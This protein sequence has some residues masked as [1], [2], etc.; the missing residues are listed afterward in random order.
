M[1]LAAVALAAFGCGAPPE[2]GETEEGLT[3]VIHGPLPR[4]VPLPIAQ[5]VYLT[6]DSVTP[7]VPIEGQ[8]VQVVYDLWNN[9][10]VVR[11]GWVGAKVTPTNSAPYTSAMENDWPVAQLPAWAFA[12][13]VATFTA[14]KADH[15]H[16]FQLYYYETRPIIAEFR[17]PGPAV[18]TSDLQAL[19][20]GARYYVGVTIV[21]ADKQREPNDRKDHDVAVCAGLVGNG[22]PVPCRSVG[23]NPDNGQG[24]KDIGTLDGLSPVLGVGLEAGPFVTVP[25]VGPDVHFSFT[26]AD[27]G[28]LG[29]D[30]L[31]AVLDGISTAT[32]A[33]LTYVYPAFTAAWAALNTGT[34]GLNQLMFGECKGLVADDQLTF[35]TDQLNGYTQ[36]TPNYTFVKQ[37]G[38]DPLA[39]NSP[40]ISGWQCGNH[41]IYDV[42]YIIHRVPWQPND[43]L[44]VVP[45][46]KR[47]SPA[48]TVA[49]TT[50]AANN[51]EVTWT[52][53]S[54]T[55]TGL[56]YITPGG[57]FG[58][59]QAIGPNDLVIIQAKDID[60]TIGH[61]YVAG[62]LP[63]VM[64][65]PH[66]PLVHPI[67]P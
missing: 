1:F 16:H 59:N 43:R 24:A 67:T 26:A 38:T 2:A 37:Y 32:A 35:T 20:V 57:V 63:P 8:P 50:N 6:I 30:N 45:F 44:N 48:A 14:P 61:A 65:V 53:D 9:T 25:R 7:A 36:T 19:D 33:V 66:P 58:L 51:S 42:H 46:V 39:P 47:L 34:A 21:A 17:Q 40:Y 12:H 60:G 54:L 15:G 11:N 55:P 62:N 22:A 31:V 5:G 23:G 27:V 41:P 18:A 10:G 3:A 13:G 64:V 28:Q 49:F 56:G 4:P 52:L 29:T